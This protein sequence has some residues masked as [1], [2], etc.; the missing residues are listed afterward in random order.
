MKIFGLEIWKYKYEEFFW[1]ITE[2]LMSKDTDLEGKA[3]FTPNPEICLKTLEDREFWELLRWADY[4]T[5]D[6]I[7]LYIW[8]Q[9]NDSQLP[10]A[11]QFFLLPVNTFNILFR[12]KYLYEKYGERICGSDITNSLLEFSQDNDIWIAIIDPSYPKDIEKCESQR[13]F[14]E[15]FSKKF[16]KLNFDF[17]V[18]SDENSNQI[19]EN[20]H[21]SDAQILF[22][23]LWMKKQEISVIKWLKLCPK[24]KLGLGIG[25][26]FDYHTWFQKRAPKMFRDLGFEWLYRIFTSPNKLKRLGRIYQAL[27]VFPIK[28]IIDKK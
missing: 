21:A 28:V 22:S 11:L 24:L 27:I 15:K 6:G 18:Y 3:I 9:I 16:P 17:Y 5:S 10:K 25:S 14:R 2:F 7:G 26:S 1:E 23:T 20:I 19:F 8:Y 4:L 13:T 12:K